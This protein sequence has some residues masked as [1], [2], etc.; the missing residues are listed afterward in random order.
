MSLFKTIS[1]SLFSPKNGWKQFNEDLPHIKVLTNYLIPL[2]IVAVVLVFLGKGILGR[3]ILNFFNF[4][5][6]SIKYL[7]VQGINYS[8]LY[9]TIIIG[10]AYLTTVLIENIFTG[11]FKVEKNF[12]KTFEFVAYSFTPICLATICF[13]IPFMSWA[14]YLCTLYSLVL[15]L[16][17]QMSRLENKEM[18]NGKKWGYSL[19]S[20]GIFYVVYWSLYGIFSPIFSYFI[21]IF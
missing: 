19:V 15:L 14:F 13:I 3:G 2:T 8:M 21:Y 4:P 10:G 18:A 17:A 20:M 11:V 9:A 12:N 7:V 6:Y 1:T 5:S 16:F